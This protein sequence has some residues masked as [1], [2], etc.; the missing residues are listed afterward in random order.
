[1][2][3]PFLLAAFLLSSSFA[4][5]N[6]AIADIDTQLNSQI[7]GEYIGIS[8]PGRTDGGNGCEI[9][10]SREKGQISASVTEQGMFG[11]GYFDLTYNKKSIIGVEVSGR[12]IK[13]KMRS[14][15]DQTP[16]EAI[17]VFKADGR[18]QS[19]ELR[20]ENTNFF[21]FKSMKSAVK[22]TLP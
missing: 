10:I 2:K 12:Q 20:E 9:G 3:T 17:F 7:P 5:A 19:A 14:S 1:M 6:P 4:T 16:Q 18:L 15:Q 8:I 21:G 22:C 13:L 11:L